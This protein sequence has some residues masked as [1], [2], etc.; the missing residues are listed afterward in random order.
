MDV[1][2]MVLSTKSS[3]NDGLPHGDRVLAKHS[4][5]INRYGGS[6]GVRDHGLLEA[7][8]YPSVATQNRP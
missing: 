4:D 2:G 7:A 5:Q 1:E 3:L 6:H 8:L